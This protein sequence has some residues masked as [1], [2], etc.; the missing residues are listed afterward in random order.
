M[1]RINQK[2]HK[3]SLTKGDN[4][5]FKVNIIEANGQIRQLF[6]DDTITL[7]NPVR[8]PLETSDQADIDRFVNDI[9]AFDTANG[10]AVINDIPGGASSNIMYDEATHT[11]SFNAVSA[12]SNIRFILRKLTSGYLT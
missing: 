1:F 11:I 12:T 5:S 9:T 6:D 4:A 2:T 3:I 8:V 10:T 7:T